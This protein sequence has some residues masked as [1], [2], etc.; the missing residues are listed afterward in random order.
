M[1]DLKN[2]IDWLEHQTSYFKK[3]AK[4]GNIQSKIDIYESILETVKGVY[5]NDTTVIQSFVIP[6]TLEPVVK[7]P[8]GKIVGVSCYK[9]EE[10]HVTVMFDNKD[11][12]IDKMFY[13]IPDG[14]KMKDTSSIGE[15]YGTFHV[16]KLVHVFEKLFN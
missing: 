2:Q 6:I 16:G 4:T 3:Q 8:K 5:K 13:V 7:M 15:F 11:D 12:L 14:T 1:I 10:L 9:D